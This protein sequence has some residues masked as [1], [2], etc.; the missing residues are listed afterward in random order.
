MRR[1]M[2]AGLTG[3]FCVIAVSSGCATRTSSADS[4]GSMIVVRDAQNVQPLKVGAGDALGQAIFA[5]H[6]AIAKA[7]R[8]ERE[9]FAGAS[10]TQRPE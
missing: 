8:L 9:Q 7:K 5:N 4:T 3:C 2:L 6:V 10:E 1:M